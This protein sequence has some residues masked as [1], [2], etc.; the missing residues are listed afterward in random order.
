[1][2]DS[3][4]LY[5]YNN[6]DLHRRGPV[7]YWMS[8]DQRV[9]DNW[10]LL[11]AV[12]KANEISVPLHV[13]FAVAPAFLNA[14]KRH[15]YF[16]LDGLE[17]VS[18]DLNEKG[19]TFRIL[20][21]EPDRTIKNYIDDTK[22]SLIVSDFDPLKVKSRWKLNLNESLLI[23]HVEVDAHNIVP[24]RY[25]SDKVEFAAHTIRR[26]INRNLDEYLVKIPELPEIGVKSNFNGF[27][28][29]KVL[30]WLDLNDDISLIK[31]LKSG[32]DAALSTFQKFL[33]H[34]LQTYAKNRNDPLLDSQ[35]NLSPFLHLGQISSQR[36]A[37]KVIKS[38]FPEESKAAF[39]DEL[40]VRK[41]LSD[42]YC[43]YNKNYDQPEGFHPW[44]KATLDKHD[45]DIR[46]FLYLLNVFENAETHDQLWNAA[47]T[48]LV[49]TGKMHGYLRMYW[50][51]KIKEWTKDAAQA[52]K[53]AIY[54][55][56]RYSLDGRDPN[57]YAGIAWSIGGIH[58]RAWT[59]RPVFG[60]IRYM[61][62]NGCRRKF[63][64]DGYIE[65]VGKL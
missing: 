21:G 56:D 39:L 28:K 40:I 51:K 60:K 20:C 47:Q 19:I 63:D 42:N 36:I 15:Y 6:Y 32:E 48:Q 46:E 10:A 24:C 7:L 2:I 38:D 50:A 13:I 22:A 35:S 37:F 59:E 58:D 44:A 16:M 18:I 5:F 8:R 27:C 55:N 54:L 52:M 3:S 53:F 25:V 34:K 57:G 43:F 49:K 23:P 45:K 9:H 26:K 29:E 61:N 33:D 11:Y 17:K 4:R 31:W 41:E 30:E 14:V 65:R 62:L 1:M 12:Q 64:V